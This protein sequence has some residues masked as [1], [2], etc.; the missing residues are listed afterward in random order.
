MLAFTE[1]VPPLAPKVI[2]RLALRVNVLVVC[3]VPPLRVMAS[4]TAAPGAV[5][6]KFSVPTAKAPPFTCILPV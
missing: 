6:K 2:P 3:S 1:N 5:P 4:A